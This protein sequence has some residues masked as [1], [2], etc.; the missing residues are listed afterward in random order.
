MNMN[1]FDLHCDTPFELFHRK[2]P[3][4]NGSTH[5]TA[6]KLSGYNK[7]AQIMDIWS[8]NKLGDDEAYARF[9]KIC[10]N[11]MHELSENGEFKF[12]VSKSDLLSA[13]SG[14]IRAVFLGVEGANLL[15][16]DTE[17]LKA[18]YWR[19]VRFLTLTWAG[20]S[21]IGGAHGT[22]RGLTDFGRSVV[23]EC[24]R[25]GIAVDISHG[26]DALTDEVTEMCASLKIPAIASHSD[27]RACCDHS[28]NLTDER[29][30]RIARSGGII[31]VNLADKHLKEGGGAEISDVIRHV[32]RYLD[33]G[34][35]KSLCMG[36]D[37]DGADLPAGIDDV[38]SVTKIYDALISGGVGEQT[39]ED[40]FYG[41]AR[42]FFE[43]YM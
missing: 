5:I 8:D 15:G 6:E 34:L 7:Y 25:L 30:K 17:R 42:R 4:K 35:E 29:A 31:G 28:R 41:N 39:A 32:L 36:C 16:G 18:L 27:L 13:E 21:C 33:L 22:A 40:I 10:D 1:Y 2:S 19:G 9:F 38:S 20:E 24:D 43:K 3:L 12:C 11:F 26:S 23:L 37:L 14:G